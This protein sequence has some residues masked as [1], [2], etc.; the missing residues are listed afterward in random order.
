LGSFLELARI[1]LNVD[2]LNQ[3]MNLPSKIH[4]SGNLSVDYSEKSVIEF[5]DVSFKYPGSDTYALKNVNLSINFNE[6][7]CIVGSNGAGKSTFVK[8]LTRL[9]SPTE[10]IILLN[11]RNIADYSAE[12]YTELFAPV[13]QDFVKYYF[14]IGI[15]IALTPDYDVNK[16]DNIVKQ[17][18]LDTLIHK[19]P[20]GYDTQVGKL[21]DP[22]GFEP[23]GGENQRIAIARAL[24]EGGDIYILDEPT[25]ALD[26]NAEYEIYTQFNGMI[27]DKTAVLITHRLSAV[28]LA[29]K[30]AVFDDG[31]I[32]EYGTH[33][34]LYAKGGI[35]TEM[36]D[37][38]A[39]FYRDEKLSNN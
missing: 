4:A 8:L 29:D 9:Y 15:N 36:F 27:K 20:K 26:P 18:H 21:V 17:C 5:R 13:F 22:T 7:L 1:S 33:H 6:K 11:G 16:L 35:Y 2:E 10:G 3:F 14:S 19:L 28:Q 24:Y 31:Q 12:E 32:V 38:Q 39:R 34:E 37:K 23:S 25:A 30:V